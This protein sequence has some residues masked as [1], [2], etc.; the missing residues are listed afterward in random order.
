MADLTFAVG[1]I[2]VWNRLNISSP[3]VPG[4]LDAMLGLAMP[5]WVPGRSEV[6]LRTNFFT[7][8][9]LTSPM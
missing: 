9:P 3:I 5:A 8:A 6:S 2:N 7:F 4:S 1:I